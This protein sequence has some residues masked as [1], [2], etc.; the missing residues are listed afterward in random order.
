M[1]V[2]S[3]RVAPIAWTMLSAGVVAFGFWLASTG[4]VFGDAV[5]TRVWTSGL[6][7]ILGGLALLFSVA[8]LRSRVTVFPD[9]LEAVNGIGRKR[10]IGP[11]ELARFRA[12]GKGNDVISGSTFR[13]RG[14]TSNRF[15]RNYAA[16][17][18]WLDLNA[19]APWVEFKE[20]FG[21][22]T[23]RK[24]PQPVKDVFTTLLAVGFFIITL[25]MLPGLWVIS[26]YD[27]AHE[28][29]V[30]CSV[31]AA[32]AITVSS[33][34]SKGIGS[35]RPGVGIETSNCG[36]L[37]LTRGVYDDNR[38]DI[39]QSLNHSKGS[40]VFTVGGGTFW[41]RENMS[42]FTF[43]PSPTVYNVSGV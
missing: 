5:F 42:W 6:A 30:T 29:Q 15:H 43:V 18:E 2:R 3:S 22:L 12:S 20:F 40:H 39:A 28:E 16:L 17:E 23:V 31:T 37:T 35:S 14:F 9:R 8:A 36:R 38:D 32:E 7:L 41:L 4:A 25:L 27:D 1:T 19:G 10:V 33:T 34:S 21:K 13:G 26:A 24:G 11:G